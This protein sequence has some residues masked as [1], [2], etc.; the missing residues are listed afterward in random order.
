MVLPNNSCV[1]LDNLFILLKPQFPPR[2]NDGSGG[3][4]DTEWWFWLNEIM[5][6]KYPTPSK[7]S[8]YTNAIVKRETVIYNSLNP[9]TL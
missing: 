2:Q 8:G 1:A 3:T 9:L 4:R 6:T 5:H 7:A